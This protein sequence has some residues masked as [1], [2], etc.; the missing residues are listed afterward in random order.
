MLNFIGRIVK[1]FLIIIIGWIIFDLKISLKHFKHSC[2][3]TSMWRYPVLYQLYSDN[4]LNYKFFI[5]GEGNYIKEISETTN[6]DGYPVIFVPGNNAPGF[7]VRSIGSI[8]Q[9]KTEKLNSPFTFNVFSVDFYEEFNI[10]DTNI[11]RRQVKFLIESLIELEKL[12]KNKRKKKYVLMGHSMGGI[13]IKMALYESEWLRNN[14]G[15]IITM[16][17]P[18]KSHP[19]KIT[20]DFDKI[21][22]DISTI[23]TVPTISIHGGLMDELIEESL[24][25]DN[26]SLTFGTQ[27]MDR[28]WSMADH[29][30][31]VWCNQEQRSISRLLFE[32]VKQNEDAFSLNNIG[33]TVQNIFNS[34]TFTYNDIDKNEMSKM[35]NQI[36]NVMLTGGRY[37]FGFGKKDSILPLLYKSK[38]ENNN[39]TI[40]IRNYFYDNSIK[41]T[42]SLEIIDSKKIYYTNNNTK[43]NIIKN[44]EIDALYPFIYKKR[45]K[46]NGSHIKAFTIPFISHEIIYSI[47]IKNKG[48]LRIYFKSKYQEASS[49]NNDLI[50]NFFDRN[51]NEN[52]ILFIMPNLLLNEDEK[53]YNIYYKIDIGLTIL[54]VFK[55]NISILPFIICFASIL[56]SL[57]INIFIK[58]ILL[59]IVIHSIT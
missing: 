11:L 14:V 48:N 17:T 57:N 53:Y 56:F 42:F 36:D 35:F 15:F 38:S 16:G 28:V 58:V 22:N 25:K 59:D 4:K 26:T 39:M 6:L 45:H 21:F 10:F 47:S 33:D 19:L 29:K 24:T 27:S 34:T 40:P 7:M 54:R 9:N 44:N 31:L 20:R 3:M 12:Y 41:Y 2:L 52:G 37:I 49:I 50:F 5:Y 8:L 13:V 1:L 55:L 46:N 18:L 32:Y 23:T 30:C 51:D 43:I